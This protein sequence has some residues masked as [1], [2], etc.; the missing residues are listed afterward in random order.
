MK[1]KISL[2]GFV[3]RVLFIYNLFYFQ[4]FVSIP[5]CLLTH[6]HIIYNTDYQS[7]T[8]VKS[9]LYNVKQCL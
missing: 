9:S 5:G 4:T 3:Y 2:K 7:S 1:S 8:I 6:L